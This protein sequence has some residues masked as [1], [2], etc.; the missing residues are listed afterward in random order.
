MSKKHISER[1][2]WDTL[3]L[4]VLGRYS[5]DCCDT[6]DPL[7]L[8]LSQSRSGVNEGT[9]IQTYLDHFTA[10]TLSV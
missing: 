1:A 4:V 2:P 7:H 9:S 10:K 6:H 5:E 8:S 3:D